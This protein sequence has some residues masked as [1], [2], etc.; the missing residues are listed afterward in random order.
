MTIGASASAAFPSARPEGGRLPAAASAPAGATEGLSTNVVELEGSAFAV[1]CE[2]HPSDSRLPM[3]REKNALLASG[4]LSPSGGDVASMLEVEGPAQSG[5]TFP[6]P[7]AIVRPVASPPV[8]RDCQQGQGRPRRP[9]RLPKR[10][11]V[12]PGSIM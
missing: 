12:S 2:P 10:A 3:K 7:P 6:L 8:D 9:D 4:V 11:L 1:G 5:D